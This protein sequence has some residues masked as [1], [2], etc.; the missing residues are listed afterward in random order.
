MAPLLEFVGAPATG[1][2]TIVAALT[3]SVLPAAPETVPADGRRARPRRLVDARDLARRPRL[4]GRSHWPARPGALLRAACTRPRLAALMLEDLSDA[5]RQAALASHAPE[6]AEF[7]A[8]WAAGGPDDHRDPEFLAEVADWRRT[9]LELVALAARAPSDLVVMLAEGLVQRTLS[10]LGS[11]AD[12]QVHHDDALVTAIAA[13]MPRPA[14]IVHLVTDERTLA[15]RLTTREAAGVAIVRHRGLTGTERVSVSLSD[16]VL[17]ARLS[18]LL[19]ERGVPL[20][21]VD[22]SHDDIVETV[23]E[24]RAFAAGLTA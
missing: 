10:V 12:L 6:W 4:A 14:G 23:R 5:E 2:S 9:T 22:T 11:P 3:C 20:L 24:V 15:S 1:K 17:L 8:L 16:A 7:L 19:A 21:E 13:A 18:G